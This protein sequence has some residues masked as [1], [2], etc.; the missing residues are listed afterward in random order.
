MIMLLVSFALLCCSCPLFAVTFEYP[1]WTY[2]FTGYLKHESA[3][4]TRQNNGIDANEY[5][6]YPEPPIY[7]TQH[8]DINH[9]GQHAFFTL[10]SRAGITAEGPTI[11]SYQP[12]AVVTADFFGRSFEIDAIADLLN[13][14]TMRYAYVDLTNDRWSFLCGYFWHL[15][16]FDQYTPNSVSNNCGD[17]FVVDSRN[18]QLRIS[19]LGKRS[20]FSVALSTQLD[21]TSDGPI[22]FDTSYSKN[23]IMPNL[24]LRYDHTFGTHTCCFAVDLKRL[25]PRLQTNTGYKTRESLMSGAINSTLALK[26]PDKVSCYSS[27]VYGQNM[28]NF[29]IFGGYAVHTID[30]VTDVRTY[31][32][33]QGT[34]IQTDIEILRWDQRCVPGIFLGYG[35]NLGARTSIIDDQLADDGSLVERRVYGIGTTIDHAWRIAPRL[36]LFYKT[37]CAGIELE[38]TQASYGIRDT[39]AKV[40]CTQPVTNIR[41]LSAVYYIF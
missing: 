5:L 4:D 39:H 20:K 23:A 36:R 38:C 7:D 18:P 33:L 11:K 27:L 1:N 30:P 31:A 8:R 34:A 3:Y 9:R 32:N 37:V 40:R 41:L 6:L 28:T 15:F 12:K 10:E 21:Y 16:C 22:G 13:L 14:A 17:P 2:T 25:A 19:K 24:T 26:W 35:K 29:V